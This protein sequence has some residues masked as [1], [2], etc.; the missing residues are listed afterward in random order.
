MRRLSKTEQSKR[1]QENIIMGSTTFETR[2]TFNISAMSP[3]A[4]AF[5]AGSFSGTCSTLLLQPLDLI[6]TKMQKETTS[7][8]LLGITKEVVR[9]EH[10]SGLWRGLKPSL[11]RTVP[12]VGIYFATLHGIRS[13]FNTSTPMGSMIT[14]ASARCFAGAVMIPFT[15]LKVR[16][17][18]GVLGS[19]NRLL[20]GLVS[21]YRKEGL[22]GLTRGV[23]PTLARDAPFSGLYLLFYDTLKKSTAAFGDNISQGSTSTHL[24]CGVGA[25][26]L[27]SFVTHPADVI[28]TKVQLG[29]QGSKMNV[30]KAALAIYSREGAAGL[31]TGL[32]PRMLRRSMMASLAWMVYERVMINMGIKGSK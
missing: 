18:A 25:G 26:C 28:K 7:R 5:L 11:A 21:I 2:P 19:D 4:K 27:A 13:K 1:I 22:L 3:M 23:L 14:G 32:G 24:L 30:W 6:K 31:M 12:G 15:I 29:E 17:E 16:S 8:S 20:S 9:N 10:L